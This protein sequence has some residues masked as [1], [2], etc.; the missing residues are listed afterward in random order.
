MPFIVVRARL[1][2]ASWTPHV[3]FK[4]IIV[5]LSLYL[6]VVLSFCLCTFLSFCL[7]SESFVNNLII[8]LSQHFTPAVQLLCCFDESHLAA[9]LDLLG[10]VSKLFLYFKN[11]I[12]FDKSHFKC[13]LYLDNLFLL[14]NHTS[15]I[16]LYLKKSNIF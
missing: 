9:V 12:F 4:T 13:F 10:K 15:N 3:L 5:F 7:K 8:F 6:L 2:E 11:Q 14:T 16:C 1:G